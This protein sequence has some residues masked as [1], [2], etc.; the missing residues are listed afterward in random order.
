[1][2]IPTQFLPINTNRPKPVKRGEVTLEKS[3][4]NPDNAKQA[5][6][7]HVLLYD[8]REGEERRKRKI[9]PL[10]DTRM[11]RDRRYDKENPAIDTKA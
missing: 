1:M 11:G 3:E 9:K 2:L 7:S 5:L 8:K 4:S 6:N 10:L